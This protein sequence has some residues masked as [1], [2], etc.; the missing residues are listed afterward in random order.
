MIKNTF[1]F[2]V[3]AM[4]TTTLVKASLSEKELPTYRDAVLRNGARAVLKSY[5][6][7]GYV[8]E[9]ATGSRTVEILFLFADDVMKQP[10]GDVFARVS[11]AA[12]KPDAP[13]R[14]AWSKVTAADSARFFYVLDHSE[15]FNL[16]ERKS[17]D[18]FKTVVLGQ[19]TTYRSIVKKQGREITVE[20]QRGDSL[21]ADYLFDFLL[22]TFGQRL[23]AQ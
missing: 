4:L 23:D 9:V 13:N 3:V 20:R 6:G 8:F 18:P 10:E 19:S 17:E 21:P 14:V 1:I 22:G 2:V 16:A 7:T 11:D 12:A 15:V 5:A